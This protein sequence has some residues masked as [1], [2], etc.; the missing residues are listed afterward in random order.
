MSR[1]G[2]ELSVTFLHHSYNF[3]EGCREKSSKSKIK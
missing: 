1:V 3:K 2:S